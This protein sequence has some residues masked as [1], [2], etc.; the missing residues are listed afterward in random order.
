MGEQAAGRPPS[1]QPHGLEN[2]FSTGGADRGQTALSKFDRSHL[3]H[4]KEDTG[5][6]SVPV[7]E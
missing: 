3:S 1:G 7:Q 2:Q 6:P 5:E 4:F